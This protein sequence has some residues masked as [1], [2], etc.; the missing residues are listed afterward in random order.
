MRPD[1]ADI[2]DAVCTI[3]ALEPILNIDIV[4]DKDLPDARYGREVAFRL[5]AA[6]QSND[7]FTAEL[8]LA[9]E[10]IAN[11]ATSNADCCAWSA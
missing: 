9:V 10:E 3:R 2:H 5:I 8:Q 4:Y 6:R 1:A 11:D 7:T